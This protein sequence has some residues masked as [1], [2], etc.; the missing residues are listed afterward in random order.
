MD[1]E[2]HT[3]LN[4]LLSLS[5]C[6]SK[7]LDKI[8]KCIWIGN[9]EPSMKMEIDRNKRAIKLLLWVVGVLFVTAVGAVA[10]NIF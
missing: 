6:H 1:P 7:K 9:G 3:K 10:A 5:E 8:Y 2:L 4:K